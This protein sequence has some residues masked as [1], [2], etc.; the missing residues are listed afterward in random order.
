[1]EVPEVGGSAVWICGW[2]GPA[3]A[4]ELDARG[5]GV[6]PQKSA[7]DAAL[8]DISRG[9][10]E[11]GRG[12]K[13]SSVLEWTQGGAGGETEPQDVQLSWLPDPARI[14]G[15]DDGTPIRTGIKVGVRAS[16]PASRLP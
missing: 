3:E 5:H 13:W 14:R 6:T 4:A 16:A 8:C 2:G 12:H 10:G 7:A 11:L 9:P 15:E 1:M